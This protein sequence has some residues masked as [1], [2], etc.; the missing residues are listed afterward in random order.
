[1]NSHRKK[2]MSK[3]DLIIKELTKI[4]IQRNHL[5]VIPNFY[6]GLY[7]C[8]VFSI[9]RSGFTCEYEIKVDINDFKKDFEKSNFKR[10][11][12]KY[13]NGIKI[14]KHDL[15]K[16]GI[17]TN[18]FYFVT[19]PGLIDKSELPEYAGWMVFGKYKTNSD[20]LYT[21]KE[22]PVLSKNKWNIKK[23]VPR[24]LADKLYHRYVNINYRLNRQKYEIE[25][26]REELKK[27]RQK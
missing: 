24:F 18:K 17:R 21:I 11:F 6:L 15:I 20:E 25:I 26:L 13:G 1:M 2:I 19:P 10:A 7:E 14:K 9:T 23:D 4:L 27:C 8:D 12:V 3:A 16:E 5:F 22:A